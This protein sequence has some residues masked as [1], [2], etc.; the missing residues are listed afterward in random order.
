CKPSIYDSSPLHNLITRNLDTYSLKHSDK[1]AYV[2]CT[3]ISTGNYRV[4]DSKSPNFVK[5][6]IAGASF[7]LLMSPVKINDE[8]YS[9]GAIMCM[10]PNKVGIDYGCDELDIIITSPTE[11][12]QN[13]IVKPSIFDGL[14]RALNL[15]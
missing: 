6:V 4:F 7:P 15:A 10:T 12:K 11:K 3:S 5:A 2:G 14:R 9:D 13:T 8:Y 1:V